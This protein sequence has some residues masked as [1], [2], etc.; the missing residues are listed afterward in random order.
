MNSNA[1]KCGHLFSVVIPEENYPAWWM[2]QMWYVH[3]MEYY[4]AIEKERTI[5]TNYNVDELG[6]V[7]PS[8]KRQKQRVVYCMIPFMWNVQ[9][10]LIYRDR[11]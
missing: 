9:N 4:L 8:E 6:N 7:M 5:D 3:A 10:R 1:E 2:N 11:Q